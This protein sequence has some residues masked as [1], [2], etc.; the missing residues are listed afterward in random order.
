MMSGRLWSLPHLDWHP[1]I[2]DTME[3]QLPNAQS[4]RKPL[5]SLLSEPRG[6]TTC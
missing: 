3:H 6:G 4:I 5:S 2:I 1:E